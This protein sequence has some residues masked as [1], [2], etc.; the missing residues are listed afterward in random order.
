MTCLHIKQCAVFIGAVDGLGEL[1]DKNPILN[2][3]QFVR[4]LCT[5]LRMP[6]CSLFT[7]TE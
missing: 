1:V 7:D 3:A 2:A 5:G 6:T 4:G